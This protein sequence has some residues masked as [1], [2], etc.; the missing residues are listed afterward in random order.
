MSIRVF[1]SDEQKEKRMKKYQWGVNKY[2]DVHNMGFPEG[3]EREK[4]TEKIFEE[5]KVENS[6]NLMKDVNL[7]I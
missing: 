3:E 6:P 7:Y 5:I 1:Q 4:G 2:I